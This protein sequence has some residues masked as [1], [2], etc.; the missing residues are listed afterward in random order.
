MFYCETCRQRN[1]W[2]GIIPTS[3]GPC[4]NCG[5]Q[6]AC[7]NVK[8]RHLM[9]RNLA[10][11]IDEI[12]SREEQSLAGLGVDFATGMSDPNVVIRLRD[13]E[14]ETANPPVSELASANG[15]NRK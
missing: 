6:A 13:R 14:R 2:P 5:R 15:G 4:E 7:Y 8:A 3:I 10:D 9:P 11:V 12:V 1:N